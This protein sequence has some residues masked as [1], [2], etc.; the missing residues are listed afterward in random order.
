MGLGCCHVAQVFHHIGKSDPTISKKLTSCVLN[1]CHKA[2]T[3]VMVDL[4]CLT[5]LK[6]SIVV[7]FMCSAVIPFQTSKK[8]FVFFLLILKDLTNFW[9]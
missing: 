1:S 7:E 5:Q 4:N 9:F 8:L 6:V 3:C 2:S